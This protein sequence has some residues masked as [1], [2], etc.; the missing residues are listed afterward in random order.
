MTELSFEKV[1][2][3]AASSPRTAEP[4]PFDGAFPKHDDPATAKDE[5]AL[6]FTVPGES[7]VTKDGKSKYAPAIAKLQSQAQRAAK[8]LGRSA[9]FKA[10]TEGKGRN[11][12]TVVTVWT[13]PPIT[14]ERSKP[15]TEAQVSADNPN[16]ATG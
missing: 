14:R 7:H 16:T 5:S 8:A 4:N 12:H 9:R 3:P 1:E 10:T 13:V 15:A 2:V 6:K 11:A